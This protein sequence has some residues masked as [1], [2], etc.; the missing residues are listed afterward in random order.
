MTAERENATSHF[1]TRTGPIIALLTLG[2]GVGFLLGLPVGWGI[3]RE[4]ARCPP[5]T[6][7]QNVGVIYGHLLDHAAE[8]G[9]S[10][11]VTIADVVFV[12]ENGLKKQD[13]RSIYKFGLLNSAYDDWQFLASVDHC[14]RVMS[15]GRSKKAGPN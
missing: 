6:H 11:A 13:H 9:I 14:R 10:S 4:F 7:N 1:A 2:I 12:K 5:T 15:F 3:G 8:L